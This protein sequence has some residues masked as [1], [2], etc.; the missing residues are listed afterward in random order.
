MIGDTTTLKKLGA[1]IVVSVT[2]YTSYT[3]KQLQTTHLR[4]RC[5]LAISLFCPSFFAPAVRD[6]SARILASLNHCTPCGFIA[7][8]LS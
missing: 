6:G 4:S 1:D 5:F 2:I 7:L 3:Y 8:F